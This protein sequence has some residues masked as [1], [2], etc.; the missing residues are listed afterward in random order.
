MKIKKS[1]LLVLITIFSYNYYVYLLPMNGITRSLPMI[2]SIIL[3]FYSYMRYPKYKFKKSFKK[4]Y[5]IVL[6]PIAL[7]VFS[8]IQARNM[9]GQ[10]ILQ[11]ISPQRITIACILFFIA[12]CKMIRNGQLNEK[13]MKKIVIIGAWIE[14]IVIIIQVLLYPK[15]QFM[16]VSIRTGTFLIFPRIY[17]AYMFTTIL[18]W[19]SISSIYNSSREYVFRIRHHYFYAILYL[20]FLIL[21]RQSRGGTIST[22]CSVIIVYL[23]WK[24]YSIKK[25]IIGG[26]IIFVSCLI[27]I[28][29]IGTTVIDIIFRGKIAGTTMEVRS[30]AQEFYLEVVRLHPILGGGYANANCSNAYFGAGMHL[31]YLLAD[32]G[33]FGILFSYGVVGLIFWYIPIVML[34]IEGIKR[35][36][37]NRDFLVLLFIIPTIIGFKTNSFFFENNYM[38]YIMMFTI[39][40]MGNIISIKENKVG[41]M[42]SGERKNKKN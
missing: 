4:K 35:Y 26:I 14:F 22:I 25:I 19:L 38:I 28:S 21:I 37:Y 32:N 7:V 13:S 6:A 33:I 31:G 8:S 27:I 10:S 23:L 40:A 9:F 3:L 17:G 5:Y 29:P 41:K 30:S 20:L 34:L 42:I 1:E 12:L 11:G 16:S 39:V 24:N 2:N 15:V 18:F 36:K